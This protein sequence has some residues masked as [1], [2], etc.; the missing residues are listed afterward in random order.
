[1]HKD[2]NLRLNCVWKDFFF[3]TYESGKQ[4]YEPANPMITL[5]TA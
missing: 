3:Q 1:M 4:T 5:I 2:M